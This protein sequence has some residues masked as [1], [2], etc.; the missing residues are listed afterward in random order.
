MNTEELLSIVHVDE[1]NFNCNQ[2]VKCPYKER[3]IS[4]AMGV[5][6]PEPAQDIEAVFKEC[7][8]THYVFADP[9]SASDFRNDY[10][11]FYH[12]RQLLNES[13]DFVLVHLETSTEY[14]LNNSTL[15]SFFQFGAFATNPDLKGYLLQWK[16]VY[17]EIGEGSFK[18]LKRQSIAG[19]DIEE[20][21]FVFTLRKFTSAIADKTARIDIVMNGR[22][23]RPDL[24]FTGTGWKHSLR[25]PGFFGRREAQFEEDNIINRTYEKKQVSIRQTNEYKFQTNLIPDCVTKE[26]VDFM[27]FADDIYIN[28]YNLN[29]HSY[30]F[31]KK[32]VKFGSNDGTVYGNKTRKAQ[33]NLTFNDKFEN[34]IKRNYN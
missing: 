6:I 4:Y 29:N 23:I 11:S 25:V 2:I 17:T 24:D 33:L 16:K 13:A 19:I 18:V 32:G 22:L 34:N 8:Y 3:T 5:V 15:G 12:Q 30:D 20:S 21:S 9:D 31:I 28:D 14:D 26:I 10:S 7:C 27:L 1:A